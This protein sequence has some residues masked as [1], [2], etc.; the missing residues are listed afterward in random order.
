MSDFVLILSLLFCWLFDDF[1][2]VLGHA[3]EKYKNN[4]VQLVSWEVE[5]F[6]KIK[7][8]ILLFWQ[9]LIDEKWYSSQK[10]SEYLGYEI[11]KNKVKEK[12]RKNDLKVEID[13]MKTKKL[14]GSFF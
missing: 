11:L 1:A 12:V 3:S 8:K 14:V 5:L 7:K 6:W 4:S 10:F 9:F 2:L 13:K